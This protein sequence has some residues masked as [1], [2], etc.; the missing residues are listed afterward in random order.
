MA[1]KIVEK[2]I[3]LGVEEGRN[4]IIPSKHLEIPREIQQTGIR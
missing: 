3:E 4:I 2:Q 1:C